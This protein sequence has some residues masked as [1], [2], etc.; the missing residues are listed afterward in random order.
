MLD[1]LEGEDQA[2]GVSGNVDTSRLRSVHRDM[3]QVVSVGSGR[4]GESG[5]T[6]PNDAVKAGDLVYVKDPY[7]IGEPP[8]LGECLKLSSTSES[9]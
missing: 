8:T 2:I 3:N 5:Y 9:D 4:E 1:R 6:S 7:G